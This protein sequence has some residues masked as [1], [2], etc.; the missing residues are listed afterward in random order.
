MLIWNFKMWDWKSVTNRSDVCSFSHALSNYWYVCRCL[1]VQSYA[2]NGKDCST[3]HTTSFRVRLPLLFKGTPI[4]VSPPYY[5]IVT[6]S[7]CN[8]VSICGK[9]IIHIFEQHYNGLWNIPG[10]FCMLRHLKIVSFVYN[11]NGNE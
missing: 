11:S 8:N 10:N 4:F 7:I 3:C 6:L 9:L 1:R 2:S 5:E